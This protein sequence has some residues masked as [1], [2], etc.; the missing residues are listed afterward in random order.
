MLT[1]QRTMVNGGR[2][3]D[4]PKAPKAGFPCKVVIPASAVSWYRVQLPAKSLPSGQP[5]LR[6]DYPRLRTILEGLLED[7]L[8][9]EPQ[10][11]HFAIGPNPQDSGSVWVAVCHRTWLHKIIESVR[12][13]G[14]QIDSIS[15]EMHPARSDDERQ[16]WLCNDEGEM[17]WLWNDVAGVHRR[18]W[19]IHQPAP[20]SNEIPAAQIRA[21]A[22]VGEFA[23]SSLGENVEVSSHTDRLIQAAQSRWSLAQ[24]DLSLS[25]SW[26]KS[27]QL[28][29]RTWMQDAR[30]R[31]M[32]FALVTLLLVHLLGLQ[33]YA[34]HAKTILN[35]QKIAINK[36]L[37]ETFPKTQVVVDAP[38]Q[39]QKA[40]E[41]LQKSSG[42]ISA[43]DLEYLLSHWGSAL[44]SVPSASSQYRPSQ[45][46]YQ[47]GTIE[48]TGIELQTTTQEALQQQLTAAHIRVTFDS[49][50]VRMSAAPSSAP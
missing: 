45:I 41:Q 37:T 47:N 5:W 23:P 46:Q 38:A 2:L 39:M 17:Y 44:D 11:V 4:L 14:F 33:A 15:P 7:Q 42:Q 18:P 30:W 9:D 1:D 19:H 43:S 22:A 26:D 20:W 24:F 40:V 3:A 28:G 49:N 29:W 16:G 13:A 25:H 36:I 34:W 8:L 48:I 32:R 21:E 12:S 27:L 10:Q 6:G 31:P 35:E 50:K